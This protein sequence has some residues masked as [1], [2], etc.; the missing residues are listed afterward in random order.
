[1]RHPIRVSILLAATLCIA[2]VHAQTLA[3][4]VR[5]QAEKD[6]P[7]LPKIPTPVDGA[8]AVAATSTLAWTSTGATSGFDVYLGPASSPPKVGT[9]PTPSYQATALVPSTKYYWKV[10]A[11]NKKG[12]MTGP[13]WS[14]T[15]AAPPPPITPPVPAPITGLS[16]VLDTFESGINTL[17]NPEETTSPIP[18][19]QHKW[20]L[21][22]DYGNGA[23]SPTTIQTTT[24]HGGTYA[25][26][27]HFDQAAE[28]AN[29]AKATGSTFTATWGHAPNWQFYLRPYYNPVNVVAPKTYAWNWLYTQVETPSTWSSQPNRINRLVFWMKLPSQVVQGPSGTHNFEIGTEQRTLEDAATS[30]TTQR[31]EGWHWYHL[32]NLHAMN[33]RWIKVIMD[34]HPD[35]RVSSDPLADW[36]DEFHPIRN[37]GTGTWNASAV[38]YTSANYFDLLTSLYWD[39]YAFAGGGT[40]ADFYLDDLRV[41]EETDAHEDASY[42]YS[43]WGGYDDS[44]NTIRVGWNHRKTDGVTHNMV[45]YQFD[46]KI[47]DWSAATVPVNGDITPASDVYNTMDWSSTAI[48]MTGHT[49]IWV[50]IQSVGRTGWRQIEIP[51]P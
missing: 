23:N 27:S 13:V 20:G 15:T 4:V 17:T 30:T 16:L 40:A 32:Y 31:S 48:V 2:S 28:D 7:E 45:R 38:P 1:M 29:Y 36:H 10:V 42:I 26:K 46:T 12:T 3:D 50:G 35:H 21:Y 22:T 47:T 5:W 44:T 39:F 37:D 18:L 49:S 9:V 14:F 11:K 24:K 41:Y 33:G 25:L 8:T 51:L 34:T 6:D 43:L 19:N